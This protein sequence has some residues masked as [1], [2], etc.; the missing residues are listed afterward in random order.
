MPRIGEILER[1]LK[2]HVSHFMV[3]L[4]DAVDPSF[5]DLIAPGEAH[6]AQA[7]IDPGGG[8]VAVFLD[9]GS[10]VVVKRIKQAF[11]F[12]GLR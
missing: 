2:T 9:P 7:I 11:S 5:D 8:V 4:F 12:T 6:V 3:I 1:V 10:D